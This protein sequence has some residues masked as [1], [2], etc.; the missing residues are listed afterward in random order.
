MKIVVS[1]IFFSLLVCLFYFEGIAQ[2]EVA[3]TLDD[4]PSSQQINN[5][6]TS[7]VLLQQINSLEIPVTIFINEVNVD[8]PEKHKI[9]SEWLRNP[10]ITPGNHTFNHLRCSSVP[11]D[12]FLYEVRRG[13]G[14]TKKLA[15]KSGKKLIYF[16]FPYNDLGKDSVSQNMVKNGLKKLG[17][18]IAPFTVESSDWMF[19]AVYRR[20]YKKGK[21]DSARMIGERYIERTLEYFKY[22]EEISRSEYGRQIPQIYLGHDNLI[23][24][25]FLADL[26]QKLAHR[27][28][29]F[30]RLEEAMQDKIFDQTNHYHEKW[31]ISWIYRWMSDPQKRREYMKNEPDLRMIRDLYGNR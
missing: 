28:Y 5:N 3:I 14:I 25:H 10:L 21:L 27:G 15:E 29:S 30:I 19:N 1:S 9:L 6:S 23:N 26:I 24:S 12:S 16:R 8:S 17:Y 18:T 11:V 20:L 2:K 22:F 4:L 13:E 31:G 7:R